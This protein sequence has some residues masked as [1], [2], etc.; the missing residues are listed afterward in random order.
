MLA[1]LLQTVVVVA[2]VAAIVLWKGWVAEALFT[3]AVLGAAACMAL[4]VA[5]LTY[6]SSSE[7]MV[8]A[9]LLVGGT[10]LTLGAS[11]LSRTIFTRDHRA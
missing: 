3:T 9:V 2:V 5:R 8:G 7:D 10:G 1:V 4:G 6:S 11:A